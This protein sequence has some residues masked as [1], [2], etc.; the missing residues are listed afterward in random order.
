MPISEEDKAFIDHVLA[1]ELE[2]H[3]LEALDIKLQDKEF[4]HAYE[5]ALNKK[6][7][8]KDGLFMGYLPMLVFVALIIIGFYLI[9]IK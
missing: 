5:A 1:D 9:F 7:Q 4:K 6:Y 8:E 2:Y 3:M